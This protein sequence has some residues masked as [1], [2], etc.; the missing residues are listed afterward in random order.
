MSIQKWIKQIFCHHNWITVGG[1][2]QGFDI[3]DGYPSTC[4]SSTLECSKCGKRIT[5]HIKLPGRMV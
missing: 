1:I 3:V 2:M 4:L 5:Q